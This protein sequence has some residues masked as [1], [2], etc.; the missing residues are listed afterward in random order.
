MHAHHQGLTGNHLN[1]LIRGCERRLKLDTPAA[2]V[3][4]K[5]NFPSLVQLRRHLGK[6]QEQLALFA[7]PQHL[8]DGDE[9]MGNP[10]VEAAISDSEVSVASK[11]EDMVDPDILICGLCSVTFKGENKGKKRQLHFVQEHTM[12]PCPE[13]SCERA[14][15]SVIDLHNHVRAAHQ[16]LEPSKNLVSDQEEANEMANASQ[17]SSEHAHTVS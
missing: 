7:L 10:K 16:G 14:F 15:M 11:V 1:S 2:C 6:H 17:R 12:G 3:L 13:S 5:E 8:K 4:C 9:E